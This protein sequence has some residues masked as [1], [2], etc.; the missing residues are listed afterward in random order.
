M[1]FGALALA[2]VA[3]LMSVVGQALP[4]LDSWVRSVGPWAPVAYL[5]VCT[6]A[7]VLMFPG[8][9]TK[10]AA[11]ALFGLGP[12]LLWGFAGAVTGSVAAF[13]VARAGRR[14]WLETRLGELPRLAHFDR[15]VAEDGLRIAMLTRLSPVIPWNALNYAF[16]FSRIRTRDF[17]MASVGMLPSVWLYVLSGEMARSIAFAPDVSTPTP[18]WKWAILVVG[19]VATIAATILVGRKARA[20][21]EHEVDEAQP[22]ASR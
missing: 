10:L 17:L 8:S 9:V 18:W 13:F 20:A 22:D 11:G 16:G 4:Q 6:V 3:A 5:G 2:A 14:T 21:L 15:S 12:G 7:G 1:V 19:L